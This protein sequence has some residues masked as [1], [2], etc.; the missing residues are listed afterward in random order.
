AG[1]V[2]ARRTP[3]AS[4]RVA[5]RVC[6]CPRSFFFSS[7]R[8]HTRF[9]RDWSSDVCSSDLY[10][11]GWSGSVASDLDQFFERSRADPHHAPCLEFRSEERRVGKECRSRWAPDR[12]KKRRRGAGCAVEG[13]STQST[14][15]KEILPREFRD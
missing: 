4:V 8:R 9:S 2:V 13:S 12:Q 1:R 14:E 5:A 7:R 10:V 15:A 11:V 3:T 6:R